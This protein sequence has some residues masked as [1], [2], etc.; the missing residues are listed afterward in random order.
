MFSQLLQPTAGLVMRLRLDVA[1]LLPLAW[2]ANSQHTVSWQAK[3]QQTQ[4]LNT[5]VAH[6]LNEF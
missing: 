3:R 5:I 4:D 6:S 1:K 2:A